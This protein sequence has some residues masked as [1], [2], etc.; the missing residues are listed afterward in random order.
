M[1]ALVECAP[2]EFAANFLFNEHGLAPYFACDARV[3]AGGGSQRGT[4][5]YGGEKWYVKLYYQESGIVHPGSETPAGTAFQ[6]DTIREFRFQV[7]AADDPVGQRRFNAHL[8]PRWPGMRAEKR[9][10]STVKIPVPD[11]FHE[12]VNVRMSGANIRFADY[13]PMFR[14]AAVAVGLAGRYFDEAHPFSNVQD[15][16]MYVRLDKSVSG[17][18]HARDGPLVQLAHLLENDRSGYRKLVQ[19]DDDEHGHNLPG[20]YHTVTLDQDRVREAWPSHELPKEIKHYY[21]REAANKDESDPL[22]HPKVEAAYQVSRWDGKVGVASEE[23][24]DLERELEGA[25]LAVLNAAD[26]HLVPSKR[27]GAPYVDD[28]YFTPRAT[29]RDVELLELD[30]TAIEQHQESI[31]VRHL[32]DGLS[33]VEWGAIETLVTDGGEVS[34]AAIADTTGFHPDSVRRALQRIEDLVDR[35]Y[36]KVSLRSS[37]VAELVYEAVVEAREATRRAAEVGAQA[38]AAAERGLDE[39]TSAFLAW[40]RRYGV[41]VRDRGQAKIEQLLEAADDQGSLTASEIAEVLDARE[42]PIEHHTVL[43]IGGSDT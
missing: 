18:I 10:G 42:L 19:N 38:L 1:T 28:A 14:R 15:A 36:G 39:K 41:D 27:G 23:I 16:A 25:I 32:A 2:H 3:K 22:A 43:E 33:P 8:A 26:I 34:P 13:H 12:G 31:V 40:A 7:Q 20:Y 24:A 29:D 37:Y 11:G 4:F 35:E 21:A 6:L 9:D 30:L 5:E 17:P